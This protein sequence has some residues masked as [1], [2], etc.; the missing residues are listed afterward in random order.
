MLKYLYSLEGD[1]NWSELA[2]KFE[3]S[4]QSHLIRS[5]KQTLGSTP[6]Q[7]EKQRNMT[8]DIYGNFE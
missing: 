8:I 7:Y 3:F 6:K 4:D 2:L 5:I 1:I